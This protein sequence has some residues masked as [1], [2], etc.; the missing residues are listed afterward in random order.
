MPPTVPEVPRLFDQ[1]VK[2]AQSALNQSPA[3]RGSVRLRIHTLDRTRT[4][5]S[6]SVPRALLSR[7]GG[8]KRAALLSLSRL[9]GG[10]CIIL[11]IAAGFH[12]WSYRIWIAWAMPSAASLEQQNGREIRSGISGQRNT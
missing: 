9:C 1:A 7:G 12:K 4:D 2:P 3:L 8:D 11:L 6:T 10:V 5:T